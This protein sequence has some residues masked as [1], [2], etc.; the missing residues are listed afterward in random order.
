MDIR[1]DLVKKLTKPLPKAKGITLRSVRTS[2]DG[3]SA[4]AILM[5][6]GYQSIRES[7][8]NY[9]MMT[10]LPLACRSK[11][12]SL[13][14]YSECGSQ[15]AQIL[16]DFLKGVSFNSETAAESVEFFN[17]Y[18]GKDADSGITAD[19][20][21]MSAEDLRISCR[22]TREAGDTPEGLYSYVSGLLD[23]YDMGIVKEDGLNA[24][25]EETE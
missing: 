22:M 7:V 17:R 8:E 19:S 14:V 6:G 2:E 12:R 11:G 15:S 5:A 4:S 13:E 9:R 16:M 20:V 21:D 10:G 1:F 3:T 18:L 24:A 25:A 23:R